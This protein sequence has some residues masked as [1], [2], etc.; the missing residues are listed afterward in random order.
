[1][2]PAYRGPG[3]YHEIVISLKRRIDKELSNRADETTTKN[4][5]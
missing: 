4:G 1:M 5:V 2:A 3:R